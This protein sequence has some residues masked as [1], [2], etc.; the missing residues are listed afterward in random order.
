MACDK[1]KGAGLVWVEKATLPHGFFL[2][3]RGLN[4]TKREGRTYVEL[5][6]SACK[7]SGKA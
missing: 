4:S 7:G 6:C 5:V 1:C 2:F 3:A